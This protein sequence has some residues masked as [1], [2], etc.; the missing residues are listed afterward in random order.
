MT[1]YNSNKCLAGVQPKLLPTAGGVNAL[2]LYTQ[3][4]AL[5]TNDIVNMINLESDASNPNGFGPT[6]QG[7][8][9]DT[10]QLD[11]G[12]SA[13][14]LLDLGDAA[15]STRYFSSTTLGKTGGYAIPSVPAILGY[16]PFAAPYFNTYTTVSLATYTILLKCHTQAQ[17]AV[18][19]AQIRLATEYTYDP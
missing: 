2:S 15:S 4:P 1:T 8:T 7:I 11:S 6:L 18:T 9:L 12:G 13:A 14:I 16:Q 3:S 5:A 19:T 17:T 10:D